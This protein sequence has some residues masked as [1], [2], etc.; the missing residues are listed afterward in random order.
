[1]PNKVW[2][3]VPL[4]ECLLNGK[5]VCM[6]PQLAIV[7]RTAELSGHLDKT[8]Q[9]VRRDT[10]VATISF[11]WVESFLSMKFQHGYVVT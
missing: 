8:T 10:M 4:F 2:P 6:L 1:M 9:G 5:L 7:R 11:H 3:G